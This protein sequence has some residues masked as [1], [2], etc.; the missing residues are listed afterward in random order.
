MHFERELH[1]FRMRLAFVV[2]L[3]SSAWTGWLI[4]LLASA[5]MLSLRSREGICTERLRVLNN[6]LRL[7]RLAS[8]RGATS[9]DLLR[10][11]ERNALLII[12]VLSN[13][14]QAP[15]AFFLERARSQRRL[16]PLANRELN[17]VIE[18]EFLAAS[19]SELA[20]LVDAA[21][22]SDPSAMKIARQ[23]LVEWDVV[24]WVSEQNAV[25]VAPSTSEMLAQFSFLPPCALARTSTG[26]PART[27]RMWASR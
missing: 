7:A 1:Y 19:I 3:W 21:D 8:D 11:L 23:V 20:K 26:K 27:A 17:A 18:R 9:K 25:G 5:S 14:E 15:A 22:P 13:Y 16:S 2:I 6:D 12:Y 4:L 24:R 10:P